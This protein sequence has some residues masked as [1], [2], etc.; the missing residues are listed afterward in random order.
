[1]PLGARGISGRQA[2]RVPAPI[3]AGIDA[4]RLENSMAEWEFIVRRVVVEGDANDDDAAD[5]FRVSVDEGY[6]PLVVRREDPIASGLTDEQRY[7]VVFA[8]RV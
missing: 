5:A 7:E 2:Q 6:E 8:R 1:M 4:S 3:D